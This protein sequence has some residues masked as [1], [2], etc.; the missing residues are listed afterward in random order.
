MYVLSY[1]SVASGS[2]IQYRNAIC[3]DLT[4]MFGSTIADYIYTLESATAG[5]GI[6]LLKSWGY[7]TKPYYP[8]NAGELQSVNTSAHEMVGFNQWDEK[9]ELVKYNLTT[10]EPVA[11]NTRIRS[12][13]TFP[14]MPDKTYYCK[15]PV[16]VYALMYDGNG[17]Y[18]NEVDFPSNGIAVS[19]PVNARSM[20]LALPA[21]YGATYNHDVCINLSCSRNGEYQPYVKRTYALDSDLTL[22]GIPKLADNKLYYDGDTYEA[23]GTVTR[24]YQQRA[25]QS[26]DESLT[27]AIT[28]GTNTVVK[29]STPTTETA[30]PFQT[31][32]ILDPNGTEAYIDSRDVPIPVG[33]ET[34]YPQ[35]LRS[36]IEGLPTNFSTLIAPTEATYKATQSY[37]SGALFIVNNILYKA[38]A[39]IANGATITPGTNCQATTL[40]AVIAALA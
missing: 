14:I 37:S 32:Q 20:K 8:Y 9:W 2:T 3:V 7:F 15:S 21:S 13:N 40:A 35:N 36:K 5:S 4:A 12:K 19:I 17:N 10:G 16:T 27:D 31:P 1:S 29:L 23:D 38:T 24:N 39:S 11:D 30:D 34:F 33:H 6:A 26:G 22:R 28:D 18:L 25:Y